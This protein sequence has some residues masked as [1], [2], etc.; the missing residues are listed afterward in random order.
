MCFCFVTLVHDISY[1]QQTSNGV[2]VAVTY[3]TSDEAHNAL[4]QLDGRFVENR[5]ISVG[6]T[7]LK[8]DALIGKQNSSLK[9]ICY[10]TPSTGNGKI[11]FTDKNNALSAYQRFTNL[12][13]QCHYEQP[14]DLP[15]V[16]L[17]YYRGVAKRAEVKFADKVTMQAAIKEMQ[18]TKMGSN[19]LNCA[20]A[21]DSRNNSF[22]KVTGL[23]ADADEVDVHNHFQSCAGITDVI[24]VRQA[25]LARFDKGNAED[26]ITELFKMYESFQNDSIIIKNLSHEKTEV[27]AI[28]ANGDELCQ[29]IQE[30]NGKTN[31]I[32][33][34]K[35]RLSGDVKKRKEGVYNIHLQRLDSSLDKYDLIKILKQHQ[36]YSYIKNIVIYRQKVKNKTSVINQNVDGAIAAA[37]DKRF[38]ENKDLH[39]QPTYFTYPP[40]SDG[41]VVSVVFFDDPRDIVTAIKAYNNTQINLLGN[42]SKLHLIPSLAH[43]ILVHPALAK[44][45]PN[46]IQQAVI[47][48]KNEFH[49]QIYVKFYTS[50]TDNGS[51]KI[52]IDSD[53]ME[54]IKTARIKFETI[55]MG[56][57]YILDGDPEKVS[58]F[59]TML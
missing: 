26:L 27:Y 12:H 5:E 36:L 45:I 6:G 55:M 46:Q 32:G 20:R 15:K 13:Y 8:S 19:K 33:C 18:H 17:I 14:D 56:N 42:V 10:L 51:M 41:T 24:I 11:T 16:K 38:K 9:A 34:G 28:F 4:K 31:I 30:M 48:V 58:Y 57:E 44:T 25:N 37:L 59:L 50:T 35:V 2:C 22:M 40:K 53:D 29:A 3:C 1:L 23:P 47:S 43:E 54:H 7:C 39:S 21:Q 52:T 49:N